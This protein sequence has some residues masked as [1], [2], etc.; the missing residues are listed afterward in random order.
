MSRKSSSG[1]KR[2]SKSDGTAKMSPEDKSRINELQLEIDY[3]DKNIPSFLHDDMSETEIRRA[4][5]KEIER[6][7][8]VVA[9]ISPLEVNGRFPK[10][11]DE[12]FV[13]IV[14]DLNM[15]RSKSNFYAGGQEAEEFFMKRAEDIANRYP[16]RYLR[17]FMREELGKGII[18]KGRAGS[19]TQLGLALRRRFNPTGATAIDLRRS[20]DEVSPT[21]IDKVSRIKINIDRRSDYRREITAIQAK[22]K[23]GKK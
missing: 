18:F 16:S 14:R 19:I 20:L 7:G 5:I 11:K 3:I 2:G 22:Y 15:T 1:I 4:I 8:A 6:T 13:S 21:V 9:G 12:R 17:Q 23:R 10:P